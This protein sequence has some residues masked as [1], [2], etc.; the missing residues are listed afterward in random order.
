MKELWKVLYT[1]FCTWWYHKLTIITKFCLKIHS[2]DVWSITKSPGSHFFTF[3]YRVCQTDNSHYEKILV[4]HWLNQSTLSLIL[5]FI[6]FISHD[7][8]THSYRTE[9]TELVPRWQCMWS[10]WLYLIGSEVSVVV[11]TKLSMWM[12]TWDRVPAIHIFSL[13]CA[14]P[15]WLHEYTC[16]GM[17]GNWC[18]EAHKGM[19][20]SITPMWANTHS[21]GPISAMPT[22]YDVHLG[23]LLIHLWILLLLTYL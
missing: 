17:A 15:Q 12:H 4:S 8:Y 3:F 13:Q 7:T 11:F 18:S 6:T 23:Y 14:F 19:A 2:W 21:T 5:C 20:F 22:S 1:L 9:S 10:E 16:A